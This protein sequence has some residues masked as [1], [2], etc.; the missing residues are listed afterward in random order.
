MN[1]KVG[2]VFAIA[3][4]N[5]PVPGCTVSKAVHSGAND[6]IYFSMAPNTDISAE[7]FPYH[8]LILVAGGSMEVYGRGGFV[9]RLDAGECIVTPTD[10]PVGMRTSESAVYTEITIRRNDTM[11]EAIKAGHIA[12]IG[13]AKDI[14]EKCID[15]LGFSAPE[16]M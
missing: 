7:I 10:T 11:N 13:L 1:E 12:L 3:A 16:K 14:L 6:V 8:K 4:D 2:E 5:A 15:I 9:R